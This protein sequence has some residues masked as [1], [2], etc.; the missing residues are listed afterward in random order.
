[1]SIYFLTNTTKRCM[2]KIR[3]SAKKKVEK[4]LK[5]VKTQA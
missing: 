2:R 5:R 4:A 1:M 3:V